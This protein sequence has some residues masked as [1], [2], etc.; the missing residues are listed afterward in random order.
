MICDSEAG[1]P[2]G[3][4]PPVSRMVF[5]GKDLDEHIIRQSLVACLD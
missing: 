1:R 2:W 3:D 4:E 5:I